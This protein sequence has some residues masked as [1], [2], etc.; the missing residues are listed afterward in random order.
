M[1]TSRPGAPP[2]PNQP[3]MP[4]ESSRTEDKYTPLVLIQ[5]GRTVPFFC[6]HGAG[7]N[8]LNFRDIARRL[9]DD[10]SFYGLQ[11]RGVDGSQP[12]ETIEEMAELYL[13]EILRAHPHGPYLIGGYS[14]GGIVAYEMAQRLRRDRRK[15]AL[16][17]LLDTVCPAVEPL[18]PTTKD[19]L[20]GLFRKGPGYLQHRAR[21]RLVRFGEELRDKVKTEFYTRQGQPL[22]IE[23]RDQVMTA[24]FWAAGSRYR[25]EPYDGP[26]T[27]YRASQIAAILAHAG[28]T[29]GWGDLVPQLEVMEVP[30]DHD[31]LV[32][33]P[34]VTTMTTHLRGRLRKAAAS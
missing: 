34:N 15:V 8:V 17:V 21:A 30:G 11:A 1:L 25:P 32:Y 18:R 26:V 7:G 29:L 5:R 23:L 24:A 14:G 31:S 27:L 3:L 13:P 28:G 10:Q 6:V 4:A 9:G 2:E 12:L 16:V 33:E 20:T 22:P 19:H